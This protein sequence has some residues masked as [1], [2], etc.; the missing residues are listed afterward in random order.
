GG[1]VNRAPAV[2]LKPRASVLLAATSVLG[3]VAFGWPLLLRPHGRENLAHAADAPWVFVALLPLL[4][5]IVLGEIAEG[6]LDAKAVALLGVL[7]ACGAALRV[8]SPGVAG[9]EPVF[10]LLV[11]SGRVF[12]RG[13][14]FVLGALTIFASALITGG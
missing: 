8:P 3:L 2:R 1:A 11:P 14:G 6:S 9:F 5:A 4:L 10:F 7:A 13:F 12:G